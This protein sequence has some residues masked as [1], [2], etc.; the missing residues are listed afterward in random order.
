M[1]SKLP[2]TICLCF[3]S[4]GI[5]SVGSP[6]PAFYLGAGCS[7]LCG[8]HFTYWA[9]SLFHTLRQ[10]VG[11]I[12]DQKDHF[13]ISSW[14]QT[15]AY[16][17]PWMQQREKEIYPGQ[18][19]TKAMKAHQTELEVWYHRPWL[20]LIYLN[21]KWNSKTKRKFIATNS[22]INKEDLKN[23]LNARKH[24][25]LERTNSMDK[26]PKVTKNQK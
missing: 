1:A 14:V 6:Q 5:A 12:W 19:I 7:C 4:A 11:Q 2:G 25:K 17:S 16:Q 15:K 20:E 10:P 21:K 8:K 13:K 22:Y 23:N 9:I 18:Y 24:G 3:A 26:N